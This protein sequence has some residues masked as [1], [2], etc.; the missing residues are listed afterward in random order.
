MELQEKL[1]RLTTPSDGTTTAGDD[2]TAVSTT[3]LTFNPGE[4]SKDIPITVI[5]DDL[6]EFDETLFVSL[7][8]A[9]N[10]SISDGVGELAITDDDNPPTIST[11]DVTTTGEDSAELV[12]SLS[13]ASEKNISV[14]VDVQAQAQQ[15]LGNDFNPFSSGVSF[16]AGET[17]KSI[18]IPLINDGLDEDNETF[19]ITLSGASNASISTSTATVTITD[20]DLCANSVYSRC[21]ID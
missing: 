5:S 11:A 8:N 10:V 6:D 4:I 12:I 2:Y 19:T 9:S 7:S 14:S 17:T 3:T 13:A 21:L 18:T 15:H 1:S 16:V 20:D